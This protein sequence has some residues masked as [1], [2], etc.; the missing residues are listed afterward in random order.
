MSHEITITNHNKALTIEGVSFESNRL[1]VSRDL[2]VEEIRDLLAW[3]SKC[4]SA[5]MFWVGDVL[6]LV[7]HKMGEDVAREASKNFS[8]P[9]LALEAMRISAENTERRRVSWQHYR[10]AR[11]ETGNNTDAIQWLIIAEEQGWSVAVMR[12]AIRQ[13]S[14]K[15]ENGGSTLETRQTA[16]KSLTGE[17]ICFVRKVKEYVAAK[18]LANWSS[19]ELSAFVEDTQALAEIIREAKLLSE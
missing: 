19:K 17:T 9:S 1:T 13:N 12:A 16:R 14:T 8:D 2:S 3:V 15:A 11:Q 6:N 4:E 7:H 10:A 18:P 5:S